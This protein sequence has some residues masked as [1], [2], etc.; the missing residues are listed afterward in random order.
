M[1]EIIEE[2]KQKYGLPYYDYLKD[3]RFEAD[4]FW[5]SDHLSDKGAVKFTK[6]LQ[7]ELFDPK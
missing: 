4:D 1:Y 2:M 3:A 7:Q 6:I 5:N